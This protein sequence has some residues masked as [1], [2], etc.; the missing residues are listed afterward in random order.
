MD[1]GAREIDKKP[2]G[3]R[4]NIFDGNRTR[5]PG[6]GSGI[7]GNV[8]KMGVC[9][10]YKFKRR[11]GREVGDPEMVG[12]GRNPAIGKHDVGIKGHF[13]VLGYRVVN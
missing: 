11:K 5:R 7:S 4:P 2:R 12:G 3:D 1:K 9:L 13:T 10:L 8:A 6:G